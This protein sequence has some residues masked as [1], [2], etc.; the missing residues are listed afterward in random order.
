MGSING[1]RSFDSVPNPIS[2]NAASFFYY[3]DT[4]SDWAADC[5][6]GTCPPV[7]NPCCAGGTA[8]TMGTGFDVDAGGTAWLQTQAP[9]D[10][11][12]EITIRFAIWDTG[13][14]ALDST[15]LVDNFQW[16]ANGG[17]VSVGTTPVPQ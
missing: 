14:H 16:I 2:V 6:S 1:N 5:F 11:S 15:A 10:P 8:E 13:D 7:P 4:C 3:C 12:G 17:T 9:I